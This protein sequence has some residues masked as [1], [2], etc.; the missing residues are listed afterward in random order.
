MKKFLLLLFSLIFM[1]N[2]QAFAVSVKAVS[3][4]NFSTSDPKTSFC[5][6]VLESKELQQDYLLR[7]GTIITGHITN[8][9]HAK[10][11]KRNAYFDFIPTAVT[12]QTKTNQISKPNYILRVVGYA[13][14]DKKEMIE[15]VAKGAAGFIVAGASQGI[16][17]V[18]G[19]TQAEDGSRLKSGFVK[20]YKDSPLSYIEEGQELN[21]SKGD[22]LIIKFK[23][24]NY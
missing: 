4:D 14:V 16:S 22:L 24:F 21:V 10:R 20:M 1:Q 13:P 5:V 17:F 3:L 8:I 11:G 18:Q 23:K 2:A 6:Q 15:S 9:E 19:A 12:Y 7:T